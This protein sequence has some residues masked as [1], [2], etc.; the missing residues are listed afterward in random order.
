MIAE[1]VVVFGCH[2]FRLSRGVSAGVGVSL[3]LLILLGV[4]L[5]LG[6]LA[7]RQAGNLAS[8]LPDLERTAQDGLNTLETTLHRLTD[9]APP[10]LQTLLDTSLDALFSRQEN[11]MN[12]SVTQLPQLF[13]SV[14]KKIPGGALGVGTGV[15]SAYLISCRLPTLRQQVRRHLPDKF[16]GAWEKVRPTLGAW[17][18][19][20]GKLV[21]LTYAIVTVGLFV[22]RIPYA[23]AWAILVAAVDSVPLLGTGI[24]LVPWAVVQLVQQQYA[25]AL[26][27]VLTYAAAMITRTVLEP[28]LLGKHLGLDPL[29]TLVC[30]YCGY[31]LWGFWGL[32]LAP[33]ATAVVK[34]VTTPVSEGKT[35]GYSPDIHKK[36]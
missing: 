32:F 9:Q 4:I 29:L 19:A 3:T 23:P 30:L 35:T 11:I 21:G 22:A 26:I 12:R 24:V 13:K 7:V 20:Q 18:K 5:A 1:P 16:T 17:L 8:L 28:K 34:A 14:A 25:A 33:I 2:R 6:A 27:L 15:L 31:R 36:T 10:K